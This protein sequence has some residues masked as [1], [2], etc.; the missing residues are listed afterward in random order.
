MLRACAQRET[1]SSRAP[2]SLWTPVSFR[3]VRLVLLELDGTDL[4]KVG[5]K[6]YAGI[7]AT[8]AR[9]DHRTTGRRTIDYGPPSQSGLIRAGPR[10]L[11]RKQR[12]TLAGGFETACQGLP[13][14]ELIF[15]LDASKQLWAT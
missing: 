2:T 8:L 1:G 9:L 13:V 5:R 3:A 7:E 4:R 12:L 10:M 11:T 6:G 14:V 15:R